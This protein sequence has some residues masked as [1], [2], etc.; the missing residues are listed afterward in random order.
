MKT[1]EQVKKELAELEGSGQ[2]IRHTISTAPEKISDKAEKQYKKAQKRCAFLHLCVLYL[3]SGPNP[4]FVQQ[5]KQRLKRHL[6]IIDGGFDEWC[7][8]TP[9]HDDKIKVER[10]PEYNNLM[11]RAKIASQLKT[12]E[13]ILT[14]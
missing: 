9:C 1:I 4:D 14:P 7:K 8:N 5:E 13:Y 3:E 10:K 12:I 11:G 6:S 2:G